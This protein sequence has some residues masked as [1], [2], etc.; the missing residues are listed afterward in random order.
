MVKISLP[1][2]NNY[3]GNVKS[4]LRQMELAV[5]HMQK[6]IDELIES[7]EWREGEETDTFFVFRFPSL[8]LIS[9]DEITITS[10][11]EVDEMQN[12]DIEFAT[13]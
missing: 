5:H 12:I 13:L 7:G 10:D 8:D 3:Q 11:E 6:S 1:N 9:K 4:F 2:P